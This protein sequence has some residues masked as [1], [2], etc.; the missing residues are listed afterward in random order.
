MAGA[1]LDLK[2]F[3]EK[4][5]HLYKR[6][7]IPKEIKWELRD[8]LDQDNVTERMFVSRVGRNVAVVEAVLRS[9][10]QRARRPCGYSRVS[11]L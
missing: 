8:K 7:I 1:D 9:E 4:H 6:I 10:V 5:D 11:L 3:L 2:A